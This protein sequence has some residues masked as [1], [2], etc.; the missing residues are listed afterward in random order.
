M[1]KKE[2]EIIEAKFK[3]KTR[4]ILETNASRDFNSCYMTIKAKFIIV[5][6]K[7]SAKKL[8]L[9]DIKDNVKKQ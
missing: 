3:V 8:V 5:I 7:N 9:V 6:R 2:T 1:E 4:I